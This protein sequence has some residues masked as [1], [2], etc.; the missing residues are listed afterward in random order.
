MTDIIRSG[1]LPL[2]RRIPKLRFLKLG[3]RDALP[4]LFLSIGRAFELAY[5]APFAANSRHRLAHREDETEGRN[6]EW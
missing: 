2:R 6:P 4:V 1:A 3:L 5:V